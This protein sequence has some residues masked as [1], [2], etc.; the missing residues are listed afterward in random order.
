[1]EGGGGEDKGDSID[2]IFGLNHLA[3]L[4]HQRRRDGERQA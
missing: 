2:G 4:L 1:V 3:N